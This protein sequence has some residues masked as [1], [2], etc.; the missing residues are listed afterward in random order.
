LAIIALALESSA[1]TLAQ[2]IIGRL[3]IGC[4]IGI[5]SA[6]VPIWQ[7]ECS[8]TKHR[9]MFVIVEGIFISAGI[10]MSEWI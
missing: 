4:A 6:S 3:L 10:A 5:I 1:Y 2:F 9:G 7:T 8:T